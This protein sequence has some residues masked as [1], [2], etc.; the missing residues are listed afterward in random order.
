MTTIALSS[1]TK[2]NLT[3]E[4]AEAIVRMP[5]VSITQFRPGYASD[6]PYGLIKYEVRID[7][8]DSPPAPVQRHI[9]GTA[10]DFESEIE[11]LKELRGEAESAV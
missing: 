2:D 6:D 1:K 5:V 7:A 11:Y 9:T 4:E 10:L 3:F 8:A